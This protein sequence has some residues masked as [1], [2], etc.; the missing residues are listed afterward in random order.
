MLPR[1]RRL[2]ESCRL[3]GAF[4]LAGTVGILF[5]AGAAHAQLQVTVVPTVT[6]TGGL[7]NYSYTVTNF[8]ANSLGFVNLDNLPTVDGAITNLSAPTGFEISPFDSA[9]GI[10]TF[11]PGFGTDAQ[12]F[13]SGSAVSGFSFSSAFGPGTISFDTQDTNGMNPV[14]GAAIGPNAAVPEAS[15]LVSLGAG[16]ALLTFV[17]VRRRRSTASIL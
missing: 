16:L 6:V 9:D 5:S 7:Y 14:S 8:T 10:V 13:A 15:T 3:A 1:P 11:L 2:L 4:A 12:E 17:A